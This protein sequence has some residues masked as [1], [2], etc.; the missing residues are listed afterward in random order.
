[1][2][3]GEKHLV[4]LLQFAERFDWNDGEFLKANGYARADIDLKIRILKVKS[5]AIE[6]EEMSCAFRIWSKVNSI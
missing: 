2:R 1:M 5:K 6:G 4:S 3:G